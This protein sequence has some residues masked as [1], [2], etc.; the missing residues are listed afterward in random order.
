[1]DPAEEGFEAHHR[2]ENGA[3]VVASRLVLGQQAAQERNVEQPGIGVYRMPGTPL[4][5][6]AVPRTPVRRAPLLGEHTEAVLAG[7]LGL[8]DG[9]IA[10]LV[11]AGTV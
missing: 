11:D 9:E 8:S 5:F 4:D 3:M 7:L 2:P 1:M 6:S 10:S